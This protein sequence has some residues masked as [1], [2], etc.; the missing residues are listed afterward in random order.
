MSEQGNLRVVQSA[1]EKLGAKDIDGFMAT[2]AEDVEW[3]T[4]GPKE[5]LPFA[6]LHRGRE[7]VAAWFGKM[8]ELEE[9]QQFEPRDFLVKDDKVVVLGHSRVR[10]RKTNRIVEDH[11]F[12]V[13]TIRDGKISHFREAY[14]TAAEVAAY[15]PAARH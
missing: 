14:D 9:V 2:L 3:D 11:W 15:E 6:G 7:A 8:N 4:P 5:V 1:F 13:Y 12:H 10:V